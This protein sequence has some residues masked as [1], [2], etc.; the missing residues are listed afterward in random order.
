MK[1]SIL[2]FGSL[3][4]FTSSLLSSCDSTKSTSND[5]VEEMKTDVVTAKNEV[6]EE[7]WETY[8][9]E[10]QDKIDANKD[11]IA[12][13]RD[14]KRD[15]DSKITKEEY[16]AKID[17]LQDRNQRLREKLADYPMHRT[18]WDAFKADVNKE[19]GDIG[20]SLDNI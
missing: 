7:V 20:Q 2:L 15:V 13:L 16:K 17:D 19:V 5:T 14:A 4:L 18:D 1:K 8:R 10:T 11:R 6:T 12:T 9:K 3:A